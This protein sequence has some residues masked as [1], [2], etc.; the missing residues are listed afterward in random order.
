MTKP[1]VT[2]L[3]KKNLDCL[4]CASDL[5]KL[6]KQ[7]LHSQPKKPFAAVVELPYLSTAW[8]NYDLAF[9]WP[10]QEEL[11]D[12]VQ[13]SSPVVGVVTEGVMEIY[14]ETVSIEKDRNPHRKAFN[15]LP[16]KKRRRKKTTAI[17][18]PGMYCGL[19]EAYA[20]LKGNWTITSGVISFMVSNPIGNAA[21]WR[22]VG[23]KEMNVE[24]VQVDTRS[25][26]AFAENL[27]QEDACS[28]WWS[29]SVWLKPGLIED[30]NLEREVDYLLMDATIKQLA[31]VIHQSPAWGRVGEGRTPARL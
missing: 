22:R 17:L 6:L 4:N 31:S 5:Q 15:S 14:E 25:N 21:Y 2:V 20:N 29:Q 16:D 3:T 18:Y 23:R 19:F 7:G 12:F 24:D 30:G 10:D 8:E 26:L 9:E 13:D 11:S 28:G 1:R 27:L